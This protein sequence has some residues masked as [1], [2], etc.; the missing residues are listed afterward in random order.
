LARPAI[1]REIF[2]PLARDG[3]ATFGALQKRAKS[4]EPE[5]GYWTE[6]TEFKKLS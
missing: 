5:T 6:F 4:S 2:A 3:S 1:E